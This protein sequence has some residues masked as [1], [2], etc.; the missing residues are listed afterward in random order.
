MPAGTAHLDDLI[1][2]E[3]AL[4]RTNDGRYFCVDPWSGE[5]P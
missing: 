3:P 4:V 5:Q 1:G 2:D